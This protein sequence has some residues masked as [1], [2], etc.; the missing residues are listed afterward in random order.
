MRYIQVPRYLLPGYI[1]S[2]NQ[3]DISQST[4][5]DTTPLVTEENLYLPVEDP[6]DSLP[7]TAYLLGRR[8]L[9]ISG[10]LW[11]PQVD[12][13]LRL[14]LS[15]HGN[16]R[17]ANLDANNPQ[18]QADIAHLIESFLR[19]IEDVEAD[20]ICRTALAAGGTNQSPGVKKDGEEE[21]E[22]DIASGG[23]SVALSDEQV[24]GNEEGR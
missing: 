20:S 23:S 15:R 6:S 22:E 7:S 17:G 1:I 2:Y 10:L 24:S 16:F 5:L 11:H 8:T 13:S 9:P 21:R 18:T 14:F 4:L 12:L 3:A 19:A